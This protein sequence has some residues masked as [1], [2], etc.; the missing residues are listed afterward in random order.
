MPEQTPAVE[1][2]EQPIT[3]ISRSS[4]PVEMATAA[5]TPNGQVHVQFLGAQLRPHVYLLCQEFMLNPAEA[6]A[7]GRTFLDEA[8][9]AQA[10]RAG[11]A[12]PE[13][14]AAA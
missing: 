8:T 14:V 5:A 11:L 4:F 3:A 10:H 6:I 2:D 7:I 12:L 9:K 13:G 1:A